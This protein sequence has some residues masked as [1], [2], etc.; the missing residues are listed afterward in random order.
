MMRSS[1]VA[2]LTSVLATH[3]HAAI[4]IDDVQLTV[5]SERDTLTLSMPEEIFFDHSADV[6][7]QGQIF[8][9]VDGVCDPGVMVNDTGDM[10]EA[11]YYTGEI[12][13]GVNAYIESTSPED[14]SAA[15]IV[16]EDIIDGQEYPLDSVSV[17]IADDLSG[18]TLKVPEE[19]FNDSSFEFSV[20]LLTD[21]G[22]EYL[23]E[24]QGGDCVN[25]T[26]ADQGDGYIHAHADVTTTFSSV[27]VYG[28][29][30]IVNYLT[31]SVTP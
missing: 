11:S 14:E 30:G 1:V 10:I 4:Y 31:L 18:I 12:T 24:C 3:A 19:L 5:S 27:I 7:T 17:D 2:L 22:S 28:K 25:A 8:S 6:Y 26:V 20:I 15:S 21:S 23:F 9:C 16:F 29:K 13:P